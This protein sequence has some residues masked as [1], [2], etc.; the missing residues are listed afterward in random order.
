M[1]HSPTPYDADITLTKARY[2]VNAAAIPLE[3]LEAK[4][5]GYR[6]ALGTVKPR[7]DAL[8]EKAEA[9]LDAL[10]EFHPNPHPTPIGVGICDWRPC[11]QLREALELA[12][13]AT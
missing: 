7:H 10:H 6:R 8:V 12:K 5:E 2:T 13:E 11:R 1:S 4:A 9:A 3:V